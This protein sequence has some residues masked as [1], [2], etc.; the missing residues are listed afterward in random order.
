MCNNAG[1]TN[2]MLCVFSV[3]CADGSRSIDC[4]ILTYYLDHLDW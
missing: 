2:T 1:G 3:K 4:S